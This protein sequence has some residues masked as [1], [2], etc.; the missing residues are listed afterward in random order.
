M[1]ADGTQRYAV[2]AR[3]SGDAAKKA[4]KTEYVVMELDDETNRLYFIT[5]SPE[6][7]YKLIPTS[8]NGVSERKTATFTVDNVAEWRG[9]IGD[10]DLIKDVSDGTYYIDLP[11]RK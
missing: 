9:Y 11:P 5:A 1:F 4:S 6:N 3:F 10:Y 8:K 7:G 2:A